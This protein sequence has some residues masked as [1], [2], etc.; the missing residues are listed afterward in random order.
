M[1]G[2]VRMVLKNLALL[3]AAGTVLSG[4]IESEKSCYD[5]LIEEFERDYEV[6]TI[7]RNDPDTMATDIQIIDWQL[8][9]LGQKARLG[10]LY[11][12][13]SV[14]VCDFYVDSMKLVRK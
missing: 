9:I 4:C 5:K 8:D 14:S 6:T 11:R 12:S 13:E 3:V 2:E 7:M 10:Q 1:N